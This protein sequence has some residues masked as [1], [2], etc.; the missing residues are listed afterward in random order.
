[1]YTDLYIKTTFVCVLAFGKIG[2]HELEIVEA[3]TNDIWTVG[4]Y[5]NNANPTRER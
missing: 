2:H 5:R 1:M 4:V 3:S